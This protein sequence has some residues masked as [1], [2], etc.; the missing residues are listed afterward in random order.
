MK[1][2]QDTIDLIKRWEGFR[3]KAYRCS[4]NVWTIGYG[5]TANAGVGINPK[6]GMVITETEAEYYLEKA[7]NKFADDIRPAITAD[8]NENEFG[9]FVSLAYNIGPGKF[10]GSSALRH[11][12]AGD[13]K[14]SCAN[15][16]LWNKARVNGKLVVLK[17]L[18]RRRKD[19]QALFRKP[20]A[21][22]PPPPDVEPVAPSPSGFWARLARRLRDR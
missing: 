15:I 9:A 12:N 11:F 16:A 1:V 2:N 19:E 10:K 22:T 6:P 4:A 17:G 18:V 20:V 14:R 13:K 5:T 8:I 7:V 21:H 3:A